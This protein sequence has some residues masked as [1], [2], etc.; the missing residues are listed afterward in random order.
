M[1]LPSEVKIREVAPRDGFQSWPDFIPTAQKLDTI[2]SVIAAGLTEIEVTSF[3]NPKAIPQMKDAADVLS[4]LPPGKAVRVALVP[5]LKGA[6]LA[7]EAGADELMVFISASEEHNLANVRRSISDS[8]A[9][10]ESI[11]SLAEEKGVPV[12][13]AV[14]VSFGCPF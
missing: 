3:V 9:S 1:S 11:F 2:Q 12:Q 14:A 5:N 8:L 7:L 13:G 10:L 6:Q 4:G